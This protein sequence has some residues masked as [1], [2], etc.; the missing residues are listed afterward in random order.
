MVYTFM[1]FFFSNFRESMNNTNFPSATFRSFSLD[2]AA[3][4]HHYRCQAVPPRATTKV[5]DAKTCAQEQGLCRAGAGRCQGRGMYEE[6][7]IFELVL[8]HKTAIVYRYE[9]GNF[10]S[11]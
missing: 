3:R 8:M 5:K 7:D 2:Y 11:T 1:A 9:Y 6:R 10:G 4:V